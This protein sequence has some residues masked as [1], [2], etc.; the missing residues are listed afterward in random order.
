MGFASYFAHGDR[1]A[2]VDRLSGNTGRS[3]A[4][5]ILLGSKCCGGAVAEPS[6]FTEMADGNY[7]PLQTV[8]MV[9]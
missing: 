5:V 8:V 2:G 3:V 9:A 6:K 4:E 7:C 1:E